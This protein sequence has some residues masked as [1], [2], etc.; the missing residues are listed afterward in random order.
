MDENKVNAAELDMDTP[1]DE[2][3]PEVRSRLGAPVKPV[4][5]PDISM[6]PDALDADGKPMFVAGDKIVIERHT[7]L[8]A[9][10][11]YLDTRTF[12]VNSVDMETGRLELFDESLPQHATD[13]WL[14]GV[15]MGNVYKF[16][17]GPVV[18]KTKRRGRP[19]KPKADVAVVTQAADG[20]KK[21]RGRPKG[22]KN[23]SKDVI[24]AEKAAK[25]KERAAKKAARK[26]K[27]GGK[28]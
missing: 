25:A 14:T 9:G 3:T 11:P 15:A 1:C 7:S 18:I 20:G 28:K 27:K 17:R 2:L 22:S 10:N 13:N 26:A 24:R 8:L 16:A 23:R 6:M 4:S 21:R 5:K 12:R 19:P